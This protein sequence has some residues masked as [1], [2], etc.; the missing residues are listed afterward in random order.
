[1]RRIAH[2][3]SALLIAGSLT[4]CSSGSI[5]N[6]E[7]EQAIADATAQLCQFRP[8]LSTVAAL[9]SAYSGMPIDALISTAAQAICSTPPAATVQRRGVFTQTRIVHL[10]TGRTVVI[11]GTST[12]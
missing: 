2:L 11:R 4:G 3:G 6:S 7:I 10:P 1:M 8:I 12:K 5:S 9:V